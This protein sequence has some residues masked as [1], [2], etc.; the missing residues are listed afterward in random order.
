MPA[1][2][3]IHQAVKRALVKDGWTITHDP[4]TIAHEEIVLFADL[5]VERPLAEAGRNG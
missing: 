3:Y 4:F 1:P 2:D 5:G